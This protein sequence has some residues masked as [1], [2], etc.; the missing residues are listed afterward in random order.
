M[1]HAPS[2]AYYDEMNS[3]VGKLTI[4][5]S[6]E[7]LL[8][9]LWDTDRKNSLCETTINALHK[10]NENEIILQTKR[11]LSEYFQGKRKN[12]D[13]PLTLKGTVFQMQAWEEL[14]KIPYAKTITYGQQAE[15]IGDKNKARAV[16]FANSKNPIPI[17]VPCHRV[18][19]S[20]G[21]LTGFAGGIDKKAYLLK[22]E[23]TEL[24]TEPRL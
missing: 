8:A 24:S 10:S 17:I 18:I 5:A 3:P 6:A 13:I 1:K 16:G 4:I 7:G 9:I 22:L 12:F 11:Q 21:H 2:I 14:C 19:G 15:K 23:Q 20:N